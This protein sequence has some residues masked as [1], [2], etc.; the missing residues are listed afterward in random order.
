M[1]KNPALSLHRYKPVTRRSLKHYV[2]LS[3]QQ[4]AGIPAADFPEVESYRKCLEKADFSK[5]PSLS[6]EV[7]EKLG[8]GFLQDNDLSFILILFISG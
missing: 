2:Y 3:T 6:T 8:K 1:R 4:E 7:L 5:F